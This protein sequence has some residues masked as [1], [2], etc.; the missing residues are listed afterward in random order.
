MGG[1]E[2]LIDTAVKT[3]ETG[4][5]SRRLMK[6][7]EDVA[8]RYDSTVRTAKQEIVQFLYGEDGISGEHI[9]DMSIDLL[10]MDDQQLKRH[11]DFY[12]R[13]T[14]SSEQLQEYFED[15]SMASLIYSDPLIAKQ[16]EDELAN[17]KKE[18]DILR[19]ILV[20]DDTVHLPVNVR[21]IIQNARS[22]FEL[23]G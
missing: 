17:L 11:H 14:V 15:P 23:S 4:Y 9:E 18:R 6:A 7:L 5:I 3:A 16:L 20:N 1:R 22:M 12:D 10:K 21:R 19:G 13:A 2:G 8:V